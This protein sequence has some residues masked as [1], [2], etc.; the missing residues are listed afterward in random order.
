MRVLLGQIEKARPARLC[1]SGLPDGPIMSSV[2]ILVIPR[3]VDGRGPALIAA[4]LRDE[5]LF[6]SL[7]PVCSP[8]R[9]PVRPTVPEASWGRK[10]SLGLT[11]RPAMMPIIELPF[12]IRYSISFF[13][14]PLT[15]F[16][17]SSFTL[18]YLI[19]SFS[20]LISS[21]IKTNSLPSDRI[22][23]IFSGGYP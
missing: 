3:P 16:G 6:C 21:L 11:G 10:K 19:F 20:F 14:F 15:T 2:F 12:L 8:F 17:L 9:T 13:P 5:W 4:V 1:R 23:I 18:C 7:R 22:F